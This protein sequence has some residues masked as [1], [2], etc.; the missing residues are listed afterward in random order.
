[1]RHGEALSGVSD[2][3]R[4]LSPRGLDDIRSI[5]SR[6]GDRGTTIDK[7]LCSPLRRT[8]QT[9][10]LINNF[11]YCNVTV[12][13]CH[14]LA[15]GADCEGVVKKLKSK[16]AD[17]LLL[18]SHQPLVGNIIHY[19]TREIL[20][21]TVGMVACIKLKSFNPYGGELKWVIQ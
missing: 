21:I 13:L 10:E 5:A 4:P 20:S 18:V 11:S 12:D 3:D 17:T 1:M 6:L 15:P 19:L 7:I 8:R 9:A 16:R 2:F 14:A